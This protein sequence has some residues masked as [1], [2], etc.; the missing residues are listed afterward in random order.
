V[1]LDDNFHQKAEE[2]IDYIPIWKPR[3]AATAAIKQVRN[4][5]ITGQSDDDPSS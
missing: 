1:T 3:V 2:L 4:Y 5:R